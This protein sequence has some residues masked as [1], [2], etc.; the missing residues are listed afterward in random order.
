MMSCLWQGV[1]AGKSSRNDEK[2][3][4]DQLRDA[5]AAVGETETALKQLQTKTSHSEKEL[6]EKRELL[7]SKC[8]EAASVENEL[9]LRKEELE[10]LKTTLASI[11]YEEGQMEALE[12][13]DLLKF[14]LLLMAFCETCSSW[15]CN[16]RSA[17]VCI[18]Y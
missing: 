8:E 14:S 11:T 12:K 5:K 6:K 2:C 4:E 16:R 10:N 13:V 18:K 15:T 3:L 7:T 1:L 9:S 17:F